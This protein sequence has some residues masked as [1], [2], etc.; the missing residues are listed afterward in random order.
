[1]APISW[2]SLPA[3]VLEMVFQKIENQD[4]GP[5][6][7]VTSTWRTAIDQN[8]KSFCIR[9]SRIIEDVESMG[10]LFPRLERI[11]MHSMDDFVFCKLASIK[12]LT[13]LDIKL[14]QT[15]I[16]TDVPF[17]RF[18][19]ICSYGVEYLTSLSSLAIFWV[20][21]YESRTVEMISTLT[22]LKSLSLKMRK[23]GQGP[24][25]EHLSHLTKL[26][27]LDLRLFPTGHLE[28]LSGFTNLEV[29]KLGQ[30]V[31]G[32]LDATLLS[33]LTTLTR[34]EL[35]KAMIG[36]PEIE[37]GVGKLKNLTHLD[38]SLNRARDGSINALLELTELTHLD[39]SYNNVSGDGVRLLTG[40]VSLKRL[41]LN[42]TTVGNAIELLCPLTGLEVLELE[43]TPTGLQELEGLSNFVSLREVN[44]RHLV[45][46]TM[47][48]KRL[49]RLLSTLPH[50]KFRF[51]NRLLHN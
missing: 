6:R 49:A 50:I 27:S 21:C 13:E 14:H 20:E 44:V 22:N 26:T 31:R 16:W 23:K 24:L 17:S 5:L 28:F 32:N 34:L 7:L 43:Y 19:Q 51:A 3:D 48:R 29:L 47:N 46:R 12:S 39:L 30:W 15:Q 45:N 1:M 8:L 36:P 38:I 40:L 11:N 10:R 2:E 35:R 18:S 37:N 25:S 33:S 4:L 9:R 42:S 41:H